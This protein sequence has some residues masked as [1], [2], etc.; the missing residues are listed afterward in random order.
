MKLNLTLTAILLATLVSPAAA[1]ADT[2]TLTFD[3]PIM[4]VNPGDTTLDVYAT[5]SADPANGAP[6]YMNGD[7][8]SVDDPL[9]LDDTGFFVNFPYPIN[10]GDLFDDILI[11]I[12]LPGNEAV[13]SYFGVFTILGGADVNAQ[14]I[15]ATST[16]EIDNVD[17]IVIPPLDPGA[18]PEPSSLLMFTT[19]LAGAVAAARKRWQAA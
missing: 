6:V 4:T 10:P 19:G 7:Q 3:S 1:L 16:F 5:I 12:T 14:D 13:G 11:T 17:P 18:V 9:S 2:I 8:F 15:I